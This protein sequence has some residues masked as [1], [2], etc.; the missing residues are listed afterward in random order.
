MRMEKSDEPYFPPTHRYMVRS[1]SEPEGITTCGRSAGERDAGRSAS[2]GHSSSLLEIAVHVRNPE[3]CSTSL[4]PL[5]C[6]KPHI[7]I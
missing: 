1:L 3:L 6:G 7:Q 2:S 4:F 5:N